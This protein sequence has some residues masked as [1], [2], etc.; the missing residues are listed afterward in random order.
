MTKSDKKV[1]QKHHR[2]LFL[3]KMD[4]KILNEML[5]N[6]IQQYTKRRMYCDQ[7]GFIPGMKG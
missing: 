4:A 3:M 7:M 5:A 2:P 6:R 1:Q